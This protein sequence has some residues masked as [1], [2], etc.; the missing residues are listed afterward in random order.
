MRSTSILPVAA[1]A[2]LAWSRRQVTPTLATEQV[3][4]SWDRERIRFWA[5]ISNRRIP[6][7]PTSGKSRWTRSALPYLDDHRI[8]GVAVLPASA[9]SGDGAGRRGRGL[10]AQSFALKD[11]EFRKALFLPDGGTRTIQVILSPGAD[12]AAS[13]H[14]YSCPAGAEQSSGSWTLH[15]T[16]EGL[17]AAGQRRLS[18]LLEHEMLAEIQARC[19]EKISG[20]D[21]YSETPRKRYPLWRLLS[22]ASTSCGDTTEI[23]WVKCRFPMDR[24]HEFR[25]LSIPPGDSRCLLTDSRGAV[26][27]QATET[28]EQGIYMPTHIDQI[29]VHGRPGRHLWSHAH[30]QERDADAITGD[31]RLLDEAGQLAW[32]S[33]FWDCASNPGA[34]CAAGGRRE[35]GRLALRVP[36]AAQGTFG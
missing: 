20:Q 23:C 24:I 32:R 31:V 7:K 25:G 16:G 14:I 1:R 22:R 5:G 17:S 19:A 4:S 8:E 29:R 33:K 6:R 10:R 36:V 15:A 2:L 12:G 3:R 13:F 34:R 26:A 35:S 18:Q 9:L 21:Y 30:L 28:G 11:I 27:A